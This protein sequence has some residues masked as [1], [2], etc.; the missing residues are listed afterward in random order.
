MGSITYIMRTNPARI[1]MMAN[2][3]VA[4]GLPKKLATVD[5]SI[6]KDPRPMPLRPEPIC[7]AVMEFFQIKQTMEM[8][9]MVGNK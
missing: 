7:W 3:G 5:Q 2:P 6:P 4:K 1:L 9:L 8:A